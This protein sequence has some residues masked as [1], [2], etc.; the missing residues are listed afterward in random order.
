MQYENAL[1]L[2]TSLETGL[3]IDDVL[4]LRTSDLKGRT[5]T[6]DAMKT[7]KPFK[8]A[9]SADLAK[10]LKQIAEHGRLFDGRFGTKPRTRQAVWKDVK[11]AA[12]RLQLDGNIAPHSARKTFAVEDF[13]DNG[14]EQVRKDLQHDKLSTT[15][16]YAFSDLIGYTPALEQRI[17]DGKSAAEPVKGFPCGEPDKGEVRAAR[18]DDFSNCAAFAVRIRTE[19]YNFCLA[20][21][22]TG[23]RCGNIDPERKSKAR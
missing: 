2:R 18:R 7:G 20:L 11:K 15:M 8:K 9:I 13:H 10:R 5:I 14:I 3:R 21:L 12:K 17:T 19:V 22:T 4:H 23:E 6:C 1:A 16:L